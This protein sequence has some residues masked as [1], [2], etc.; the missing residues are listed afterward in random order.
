MLGFLADA[1]KLFLEFLK[2]LVGQLFKIDKF[3]SGAFK[4]AD[5][6]I[7]FEMHCLGVAVLCVLDEKHHQ[8][9]NDSRAGINNELPGV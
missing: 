2:V 8:K 3:I 7:E 4:C 9:R 5:H 1:L 6:L